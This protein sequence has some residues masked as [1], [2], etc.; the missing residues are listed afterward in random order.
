MNVSVGGR[1][2]GDVKNSA[3]ESE[4]TA[5]LFCAGS[6]CYSNGN[7]PFSVRKSFENF[8]QTPA[9]MN[10]VGS[11]CFCSECGALLDLSS[12]TST[13]N[14]DRCKAPFSTKGIPL[15][16]GIR[17]SDW[18]NFRLWKSRQ[19]PHQRPSH[20]RSVKRGQRLRRKTTHKDQ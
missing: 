1:R 10:I 4:V 17:I 2:R 15:G 8:G 13:I 19:S 5:D 12:G 18:K 14:C 9:T 11:L 20:L 3:I 16:F 6:G 7:D